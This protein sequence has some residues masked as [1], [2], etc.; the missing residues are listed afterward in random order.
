M[1]FQFT[2]GERVTRIQ[3]DKSQHLFVATFQRATQHCTLQHGGV[4]IERG[5]HL[6]GV[7]VEP[8]AI[9]YLAR[10]TQQL[11]CAIGQEFPDVTRVKKTCI[12]DHP[13]SRCGVPVVTQHDVRSAA[14]HL[15]DTRFQSGIGFDAYFD[16]GRRRANAVVL[17]VFVVARGR[18]QRR[19]LCQAVA[20]LQRQTEKRLDASLPVQ[21]E[22][23][24][25]ARNVAQ[26]RC[27]QFADPV[28]FRVAQEMAVHRR[29]GRYHRRRGC[30]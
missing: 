14:Q 6:A 12:V 24:A 29:Y 8:G 18:D 26:P 13:G 22:R 21:V 3:F 10:A 25:A 7:D 20:V 23:C 1:C 17:A 27:V 19:T 16:A 5:F 15:P 2:I 9:D 28:H 11:D 30:A 4:L